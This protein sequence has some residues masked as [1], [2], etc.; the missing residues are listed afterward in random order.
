M[1]ALED[2]ARNLGEVFVVAPQAEQSGSSHRATTYGPVRA[3]RRDSTHVA[4]EGTPVDCVR[5][6]LHEFAP[7][8]DC[9]LSGIN[10]GGNLGA[11][12]YHSG[13]VAAVREAVLHGK[14]GIA[15][16]QFFRRGQTPDWKRAVRWLTPLVRDLLGRPQPIHTFWNVNLPHLDENDPDPEVVFCALDPMPLPL[17]YRREGDDFVYS[18]DY[19]S[20]P[21]IDDSDV[22]VCFGGRIAV[23]QIR[24][25]A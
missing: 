14:P 23:T 21:R 4:V 2:L 9:I 3:E 22:A 24:L 6:G 8:V 5:L 19:F 17:K 25:G 12:I 20:R 1:Q 15:F 11:D 13:T 18:G 10:A 7:D 16:S